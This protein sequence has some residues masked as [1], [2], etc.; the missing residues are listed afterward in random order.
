MNPRYFYRAPGLKP[1]AL[2]CLSLALCQCPHQ[3]RP[4]AALVPHPYFP[5]EPGGAWAFAVTRWDYPSRLDAAPLAFTME[6]IFRMVSLEPQDR[7]W[8]IRTEPPLTELFFPEGMNSEPAAWVQDDEGIWMVWKAEKKKENLRI[9]VLPVRP[10]PGR[11]WS[12]T[13]PEGVALEFRLSAGDQSPA[14]QAPAETGN[15]AALGLA[16]TIGLEIELS[17]PGQ[18]FHRSVQLARDLGP[19]W[20]EDYSDSGSGPRL[21]DRWRRTDLSPFTPPHL[22]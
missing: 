2:I 9:L 10:D 14:A 1:V 19:V 17:A 5:L 8:R 3:T 7:A 6:K 15:P 21:L 20:L 12:A 18:T 11:S 4:A 22:P 16:D 13:T